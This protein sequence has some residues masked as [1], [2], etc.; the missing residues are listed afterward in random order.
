MSEG[1]VYHRKDGRW[2]GKYKALDGTW[3]Y[4]YR[5]T[6]DEAKQALRQAL[7]D[8][9]AGVV[10]TKQNIGEIVED[11]LETARDEV[12]ERT[13]RNRKSLVNVHIR[14]QP[15]AALKPGALTPHYL[16]RFYASKTPHA[17]RRLDMLLRDA[18]GGHLPKVKKPRHE[19]REVE[20]LTPEQ[21]NELLSH[22]RGSRYECVFV[23]GATC[24]LRIGEILALTHDA[25]DF[26][27]GT[28]A[29][30]HTLWKGRILPPKTRASRRTIKLPARALE[31][32]ERHRE[33]EGYMFPTKTGRP[34]D[35][36][37]FHTW[38]WK[39]ALRNA[40]LPDI[41]F[42]ELRHGAVSL[43]L[44][45]NVPIAAISR[46]CGH[47]NPGVT[48]TTYAHLIGGDDSAADGMDEALA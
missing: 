14:N 39:P 33:D 24:G 19:A 28:L 38:F 27:R 3:K 2:V 23:L 43:M 35:E 25:V 7:E 30:R 22:V 31:A 48:W 29:I 46:Y 18:L 20:V 9:D 5:K 12:S 45:R 44:S 6:R 26:E 10:R 4:L 40:G 41:R 32:L 13:Q 34:I 36:S 11:W 17:A 8:R 47:A 1:S 37:N 16:K 21:V 15:I 42:H